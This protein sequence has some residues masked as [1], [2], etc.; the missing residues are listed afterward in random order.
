MTFKNSIPFRILVFIV[1]SV[2]LL[3]YHLY[4]TRHRWLLERKVKRANRLSRQENR[5]Y[6]VTNLWGRPRCI[7]KQNL[8]ESVKRRQFKKG[9]TIEDIEKHAYY[10]TK[11]GKTPVTSKPKQKKPCS[12]PTPN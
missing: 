10:I 12:S 4:T 8:K 7:A 3:Y 11:P 1:R 9:V 6:I 2:Q 5:T